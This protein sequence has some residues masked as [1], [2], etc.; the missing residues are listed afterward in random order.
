MAVLGRFIIPKIAGSDFFN[1]VTTIPSLSFNNTLVSQQITL[2]RESE[3]FSLASLFTPL[4]YLTF[5]LGTQNE[6][7]SQD[8]FGASVPEFD[9][10]INTPAGSGS[11]SFKSSQNAN[12]RFTKIPFSVLF[13][14]AQF[15]QESVSEFQEEN[16]VGFDRQTALTD[17]QAMI[18]GPDSTP[19]PG[20]PVFRL[21]L[22]I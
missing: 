21:E 11:D 15:E 8:G 10:G 5:S 14:D 4:S 3:I 20:R 7:T 19:R 22:A 17:D 2:R 6:W 9:L 12:V 18:S 13:A 1:Q 16:A